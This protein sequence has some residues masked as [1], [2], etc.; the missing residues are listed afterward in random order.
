MSENAKN[1]LQEL[2]QSLG[3]DKNCADFQPLPPAPPYLH[4]ST[5]TVTFPDGRSV[6]G[7]G[8][9]NGKSDAEIAAS[10]AALE[11]MHIDHADLFM[12]WNEVS[13]KAQLG[14]ALIKLGVYLS[15]EFMTAE[16]KSKRLQTL[17]SDKHLAK[18]FDQWKDN[19]DPDL[20]IWEPYLGEKRKA[21][22]V[23]ALLWRRF[24]TQ[25]ISV[26]APQQLQSL[27]ESL[28]LPPD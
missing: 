15:K 9:G 4:G 17:E 22:L 24:G 19:R 18:I 10:Q 21:T 28:V 8:R 5:V 11:Q 20:T 13:V 12:D 2:L 6:Q 1:Q 23:E 27:L 16:D 25:V 7:T 14:D 26:T 3:C